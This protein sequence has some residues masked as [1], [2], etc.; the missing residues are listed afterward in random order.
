MSTVVPLINFPNENDFLCGPHCRFE[1]VYVLY[2]VIIKCTQITDQ[3]LSAGVKSDKD[4]SI[5]CRCFTD[6]KLSGSRSRFLPRV[7]NH[8]LQ[9]Q[10]Q[11]FLFH[12]DHRHTVSTDFTRFYTYIY[13]H[14]VKKNASAC[15]ALS[16]AD[17]YNMLPGS[18]ARFKE[19][20]SEK[21]LFF[22]ERKVTFN[23]CYILLLS[24]QLKNKLNN[25][26][27]ISSPSGGGQ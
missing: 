1:S 16:P 27:I 8:L 21:G 11:P 7:Q 25:L 22:Y 26:K 12:H 5:L 13:I 9:I 17:I 4:V 3:I 19:G 14:S 24:V 15:V 18:R 2:P 6:S 23:F 20:P 10:L